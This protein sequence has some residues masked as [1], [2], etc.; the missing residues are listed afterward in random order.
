MKTVR[1]EVKRSPGDSNRNEPG[2][3]QSAIAGAIGLEGLRVEVMSPA[4]ELGDHALIPPQAVDLKCPRP[5]LNARIDLGTR[6][7]PL[8]EECLKVHLQVAAGD[9]Q[10]ESAA[11]DDLPEH[12]HSPPPAMASQQGGQPHHVGDAAGPRLYSQP[13]AGARGRALTRGRVASGQAS[14]P[15]SVLYAPFVGGDSAL[16]HANAG[17]RE[18]TDLSRHVG[19]ARPPDHSVQ[20]TRRPMAED[21]PGAGG[22]HG[23]HPTPEIGE[24]S[25]P[26]GQHP[27]MNDVKSLLSDPHADRPIREPTVAQL[28]AGDNPV[29]LLSER[30]DPPLTRTSRKFGTTIGAKLRLGGHAPRLAGRV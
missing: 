25:P 14:S 2:G 12:R 21:R 20:R 11:L 28:S 8:A 22:E 29:L 7:S 23:G 30:R 27:A 1:V 5:D 9:V 19:I 15:R 24:L 10:A 16:V 4:V 26:D 18:S 17:P 13:A 6:K 3:D